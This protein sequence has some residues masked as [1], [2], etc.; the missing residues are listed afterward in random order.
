MPLLSAVLVRQLQ[1]APVLLGSRVG[2]ASH[3]AAV[4]RCCSSA[5][6]A[7]VN[8]RVSSALPFRQKKARLVLKDGPEFEGYS[9]GHESSSSGEIVFNTGLVG[10]PESLT[11]PSYRGQMLT[12][13]YPIVGNYGV[14]DTTHRD[15]Y[16]LMNYVESERIQVAGMLVQDYAGQHSHW[17]AVQSLSEWLRN[18]R[19]PAL[20]GI[21]TRLLTK[22][23]RERGTVLGKIEFD[24]QELP[25]FVDPNARNL[26]AEVSTDRVRVYGRGN[27]YKVMAIDCG[28]KH[29]IIRNL[30]RRGAEVHLVPWNHD[31][32][33]EDYDGLFISNGPGDPEL[34]TAAITNLQKV[35]QQQ[36]SQPLFGICMGNQLTALAAGAKSYKL[37][38]GN[39]GHNQPVLNMLT[40]Q[41]F[42][43]SQN[44]GFAI[45]T[46]TLPSDWKPLFVNVNDKS[47]EGIMHESQPVFTAQFHPEATG[48]PTDTEFLFDTFMD[49]VKETKASATSTPI[50]V[51]RAMKS[52][53]K[54]VTKVNVEKIL[55]LGSGG[56]S[57]GQAGEFDYSGSQA[58]KAL[59][60][61]GLSTVLMN[62]N[63][64]SVQTNSEGEKQAD[65][66]YYLPVT[67]EFVEEVIK[68]E[69]PDGILLSM[70]GQTALNCGVALNDTGIL[71]RYKVKVLGTS[72][73]S[74]KATEDRELFAD[75][76]NEIGESMAPSIAVTSV[77]AAAEAAKKINYPVMLRAAYALGGLGSGVAEN[78][79]QLRDICGRAF[80][81]SPQVLVEKSL[82][83]WKEVEYEVVRD[84]AD[85]C[86]TVCNME[87]FDPLGVHTGDSIVVAPS[88]TLS[89]REYHM[90]REKAIAVVRHLGI[91]GEC[92]IQYALHPTSL[93]YCI[94]E[95]N[96]RLSRSSALASKATGYPLAFIAAKLA[97]GIQ[98][99]DIANATTM[100]TSA[101]FEPSLDYIVTKIPRWDLERFGMTP[102][103]IGSSMK[104][105]GEVMAI[106]R[107]FEES[108][109]KALRMVHPSVDGFVA[110]LPRGSVLK[111]GVLDTT[112]LNEQ[113]HVPSNNR[114][115]Y[116]AQALRQGY[117]AMDIH[118]LTDIDLWFLHKLQD[119][120]K[121]ENA[122]VGASS[123]DLSTET[124]RTVKQ[125][126]FA[127]K[128][129]AKLLGCSEEDVRQA[130]QEKD[131][132]PFVK[133]IDTMAAEYPAMTNYLYMTYNGCEH[134]ITFDDHGIMVL[135]C[136]PY[137]IGSSVEFDW[138]GV[139]CIR[140]LRDLG[141]KSVMVN[142]NPETVSTDFDECD[143][144]YFEELTLERVLDIYQIEGNTGVIVSVGG[145]IPNNL[146]LPLYHAKT[147]VNILGTSPLM[148]DCCED[149]GKFSAIMDEIGVAQ[150]PWSALTSLDESLRFADR[151]GYPVLVRPSYVLSGSAMNVAYDSDQLAAF[152]GAA[153]DISK[154]HPVVLTKFLNGAREVE[155]DAIA[156]NGEVI[157]H[158]I[159][160]HIE[161]AGV[162]S[163]D[164]T[165]VLPPH[166]LNDEAVQQVKDSAGAIA[167]RFEISG[168]FNM[169]FLVKDGKTMVIEC[170]LRA[171]RSLPFV[172]KTIGHDLIDVATKV[173]TNN[174]VDTS[175]LPSLA[176]PLGPT[177]YIGIKAP[178]FSWPRL[179]DADPV[180]RCEMASTG[181]VACFGDNLHDAFL[182]ALLSAGFKLPKKKR[183][184][185]GVQDSF[186]PPFLRIAG[187]FHDMGHTI[188]ATERTAAF[189]NENGI[190]S[191]PVAWS[192]ELGSPHPNALAK[193]QRKEFDLVINLPNHK[194][195]QTKENYLIRRAAIDTAT[196]LI[197]NFEVCDLFAEALQK[198]RNLEVT[199]LFDY[200]P[201]RRKT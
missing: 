12:L 162:H 26:M 177:G 176:A 166:T 118:K 167:K 105:V 70:G 175:V 39:R 199:S 125:Y 108:F 137:H 6:G 135:G 154:D 150:A 8:A 189:L 27:P 10:Y 96:A 138:C 164:A 79:E 145:Q 191:L 136:G 123:Q 67:P 99:P 117:T 130:R 197:T 120:V 161:N 131:V 51:S 37:A 82:L 50:N 76:L 57:I 116:I 18:E 158:V 46:D 90:L 47:N 72:I 149:R 60:E 85:N 61:E 171:S 163:G 83:G 185:V 142:H 62:P 115:Y 196:P 42:I 43:T 102:K 34:A 112:L 28:I 35:L 104:S 5:A 186:W 184:L 17:N 45:D 157:A 143:R 134:D 4:R 198:R 48:G 36:R 146:A 20:H 88:Q 194:T 179:A 16:G 29:S 7:D 22:Y 56:L 41:A 3:Q 165:L 13:T 178:M 14:P 86:V 132:R 114:I 91:V 11:D 94:I 40:G 21:D 153:A 107:T 54:P 201:K 180:L 155:M 122:L 77:D 124:Y 89:N 140:T 1:N 49:M 188:F 68:R 182:K 80:N 9:F 101:C 152:L 78:E 63:I 133:Q 31:C 69:K 129:L 141:V 170:N 187:R 111:D 192:F 109:Q 193:L 71:S 183:I 100:K 127:D 144:L 23:I 59:K 128:S 168:P 119:I 97:L 53:E 103:K 113:L 156:R 33:V 110:K 2:F 66:V 159:S 95:V 15:Q 200:Q 55:V 160:E 73:D 106:G 32:S 87:N 74:I 84:A 65:A 93:E 19:V 75:K 30:A 172:S 52:S 195:Q 92:N 148:I 98:L 44:H 190:P 147:D 81:N 58:V 174:P 173:M 38:L 25:G 169:Q 126:G 139:S 121:I 64:A 181:E 151:V 24:G